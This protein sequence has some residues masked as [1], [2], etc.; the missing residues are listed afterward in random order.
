[1]LSGRHEMASTCRLSTSV[2]T[3]AIVACTP[4]TTFAEPWPPRDAACL[5]GADSERNS[6]WPR[7]AAS[8]VCETLRRYGE[9]VAALTET[10]PEDSAAYVTTVRRIGTQWLLQI[11]HDDPIGTRWDERRTALQKIEDVDSAA[12]V[13]AA[14][15]Y[16]D[17]ASIE[18]RPVLRPP[19]NALILDGWLGGSSAPAVNGKHLG[20]GA[21]GMTGLFRH[22]WFEAGFGLGI[23]IATISEWLRSEVFTG[24]VTGSVLAGAAFNPAPSVQV[25]LLGELGVESISGLNGDLYGD[26]QDGGSATLPYFGGRAGLSFL[27]GRSHRFVLGWWFAPGFSVPTNVRVTVQDCFFGCTTSSETLDVG[28]FSFTTG[29]R[30]GGIVGLGR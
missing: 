14:A 9:T 18:P 1:M 2:L 19:R 29:L 6:N 16:E 13:L 21:L 25:D 8:I 4:R 30:L 27:L 12:A 20:S 11:A 17:E 7:R 3:L 22:R 5:V 28:G 24:Y 15:P 26:L 10:A 23:R